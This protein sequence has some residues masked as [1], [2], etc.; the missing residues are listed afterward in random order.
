VDIPR[1]KFV[2][3]GRP[4][5]ESIKVAETHVRDRA[6]KIVLYTPTWTGHYSDV[7]YC[8]LPIG[9]ELV[10]H[11]LAR[12]IIVILRAHPY[13]AKNPESARQL[14]RIEARLAQD[15]SRTGKPHLWGTET[16]GKMSL[17]DCINRCD[18]MISDVSGV[19]SDFLYSG[20][21]FAM[22]DTVNQREQFVENFP[23][24][25]AG[26]VL[27]VDLSNM[28]ETLDLLLDMDP[29]EEARRKIRTEY[30]GDIPPESY[31]DVFV[32]EARRYL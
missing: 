21:P 29:L 18:A 9:D 1:D 22:V 2:I 26:Y 30:L 7:N 15:R 25:R 13:T 31:A 8:S 3:V 32:Q 5:V 4:Q 14:A 11:L 24:A 10:R 28:E 17:V 6:D 23:I 19:I 16:V 12:E 20:K 27:N